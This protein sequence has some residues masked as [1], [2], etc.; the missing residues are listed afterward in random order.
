MNAIKQAIEEIEVLASDKNPIFDGSPYAL[1]ERNGYKN[2][3]KALRRNLAG[4]AFVEL[5]DG[6]PEGCGGCPIRSEYCSA[7][8]CGITEDDLD[9]DMVLDYKERDPECPIFVVGE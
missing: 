3:L 1:A 7:P 6:M 4:R 5:P 9:F 8:F 2:A